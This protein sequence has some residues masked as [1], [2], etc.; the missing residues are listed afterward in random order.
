MPFADNSFDF[1]CCSHVL[2]HVSDPERACSEL[3]RVARRGY[4]EVPAPGK[5]MLF[6]WAGEMHRWQVV[7]HAYELHFFESTERQREGVRS[8]A[9]QDV[10]YGKTYSPLQDM[11]ADNQDVFNVMFLWEGRFRCHVHRLPDKGAA[12]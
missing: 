4:I 11:F 8:G 3:M 12:R 1:V 5:D 2:E 6:A 10:I 7:A 9:W